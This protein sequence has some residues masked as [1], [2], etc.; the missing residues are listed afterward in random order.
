VSA[1]LYAVC[2]GC[3][4]PRQVVAGGV[5]RLHRK[6][7]TTCPGAGQRP[8]G[9]VAARQ[10]AAPAPARLRHP[11]PPAEPADGRSCDGGGCNRPSIGWRLYRDQPDWLPVCGIHMNGPE[12]PTR[13]YDPEETR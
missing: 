4:R 6:G 2:H 13:H 10:E 8:R 12:G 11:A 7:T 5:F 9:P 1:N 3:E